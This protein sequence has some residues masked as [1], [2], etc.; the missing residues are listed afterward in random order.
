MG[1]IEDKR[2]YTVFHFSPYLH[3]LFFGQPMKIIPLLL[4]LFAP[5]LIY[6]GYG[7]QPAH[8]ILGENQF[9]GVQIYD[10]I[11]DNEDYFY[12]ATNEGIIHYDFISFTKLETKE[13]RSNAFFNLVKN[14]KGTIFFNNLNNQ[15]FKIENKTCE[16]IYTL[17]ERFSSNIISLTCDDRGQLIIACKGIVIIDENGNLIQAEESQAVFNTT[18][19][20]K[21]GTWIFPLSS[22]TKLLV[23]ENN[24]F[25]ETDLLLNVEKSNRLFGVLQFIT[26]LDSVYTIDLS[27]NRFYAFD[28]NKLSLRDV[29]VGNF[30]NSNTNARV[31]TTGKEIW[32]A[33][34][35]SGI[36]FCQNKLPK[37]FSYL[38]KD[39]FISDVYRD[40]EGNILLGTFDK[41]VIVIPDLSVPDVI[42]PFLQDP[43]IS[44]FTAGRNEVYMGS[45]SGIF[46]VYQ[47][48]SIQTISSTNKKPIE[49][50]YGDP[51][52]D[53]VVYDDEKI[54][55]YNRKTK[56]IYSFS[57]ASLKDVC[58]IN[59]YELYMGTNVGVYKVV[60]GAQAPI[61]VEPIPRVNS[62]IYS[63]AYDKE[64]RVLFVS[65]AQGLLKYQDQ[66]V[67]KI[68][69]QQRDIYSEKISTRGKNLFILSRQF[70]VLLLDSTGKINPFKFTTPN[71]E[72][73][74]KAIR[75]YKNSMIASTNAGL[76][77]FDMRGNMLRQFHSSLGFATKKIYQYGIA[78]DVLWVSHSGGVQEIEL[79]NPIKKDEAIRIR[80]KQVLVNDSNIL[81]ST[82][83]IFKSFQRKI[84]FIVLSPSLRNLENVRYHYILQGYE[85]NWNSQ[86]SNT[87]Q[88]NALSP[89]TYT[90]FVKAESMGVFSPIIQFKFKIGKP[91]YLQIWFLLGILLL[92]LAIVYF[93]Y[94][95]Q[96]E[97]QKQKLKLLNELNISKLTAIQ[98]QMN[99]HF[100][101]NSLN[102]IQ[103]FVL[104][105][106]SIKAYDAI[107]KFA[108]L[109]RKIMLHSEKEF[110][111][112][113][114]ELAILNVYLE[115]EMMRI[116]KDFHYSINSHDL[117]D[118]E[119]PPMLIQ[120]FIENS[121][122]HGLLH[123]QGEK[124][125]SVDMTISGDVFICE[126][127]DN[128]IGR[129]QSGIIKSRQN[130][131]H[132]S[133][134][135]SALEKRMQILKKH[136]G[137]NFSVE[138]LD[139]HDK[140]GNATGT[141]VILK[142]PFKYIY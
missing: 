87:I 13:A 82:N 68:Q 6:H 18:Y 131:E 36:N 126:I 104:Q 30:L 90:L 70:G 121:I 79:N 105:Q 139:L 22:D 81:I 40:Q 71:Y 89:G 2:D 59:D 116:K 142:A 96:V 54:K 21:N 8:F 1:R 29:N 102:S 86:R 26:F 106:D 80:L 38:F 5:W 133:F 112:I 140:E 73:Q 58:F 64:R 34:S 42:D 31:Y 77:Q 124:I 7:Q 85:N 125:L 50:V 47:N 109:I 74:I 67:E 48:N 63:I 91:F 78:D 33:S 132:T 134:A 103:D 95:W 44:L 99:P 101:F 41:G 100:I 17:P 113:E 46:K 92:F 137:G 108:T 3:H 93:V 110:I 53:F 114:E 32:S 129:R 62:R 65:S 16:L 39:Y 117:A 24:T 107:G 56:K 28:E 61:S 119:I 135:G 130:K 12:F 52:S 141:K 115:L 136:F 88:F 14:K 4:F 72:E 60:L 122:K 128:G 25:R 37:D 127:Q 84:A 94:T 138:I 15:I 23:Y 51:Q 11:Q 55:C 120:P 45:N 66:K 20:L 27:N 98:S 9:K 43:M 57:N 19:R 83:N 35:I 49:G 97:K 111:D 123:K 76:Y 118:I 69:Y 10:M 75:F